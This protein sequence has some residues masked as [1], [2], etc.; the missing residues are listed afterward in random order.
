MKTIWRAALTSRNFTFE[1]YDVTESA[2][3]ETLRRGLAKHARQY[4]R[5]LDWYGD[6]AEDITA[7][8]INVGACYRDNEL[9]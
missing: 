2:A 3:R 7:H 5:P 1:A 6:I 4:H 8:P 9:V